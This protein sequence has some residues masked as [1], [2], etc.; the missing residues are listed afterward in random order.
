LSQLHNTSGI[1]EIESKKIVEVPEE[2]LEQRQQFE[3]MENYNDVDTQSKS[4][5]DKIYTFQQTYALGRMHLFRRIFL[6]TKAE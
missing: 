4:D 6:D 5:P 2:Q 1:L 3:E